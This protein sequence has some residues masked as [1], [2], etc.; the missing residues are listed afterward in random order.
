MSK[1]VV[2]GIHSVKETFKV[3]PKKM[4]ELW[5]REGTL[6]DDLELFLQ[7]AQRNRIKVK[8]VSQQTLDK[9]VGSHQGVIAFVEG[10]P[11]WPRT[12]DLKEL[13]R[14]FFIAL[15]SIEDPN[16]VGSI[17]RSAWNLGCLG[18]VTSKDRSA[19]VTPGAEKVASGGF[20]HVPVLEEA[21]L[22]AALIS[23]KELGFWI[24]GLDGE[25]PQS[26]TKTELARKSVLVIG[27]EESGLRKPVVG[28]CDALISIPQQPGSESFNAA[29]ACAI[30]S[31]EFWRQGA[32]S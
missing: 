18:I 5:L 16:N 17:A 27:S 24:Y 19:G 12:H 6:H 9:Q 21:N 20:E 4:T 15:D 23:L 30:A 1:R 28:A 22:A 11:D 29:M 2:P 32:L 31:Y 14:G 10:A 25:S 3:R 8:R 26:L 13:D 7:E